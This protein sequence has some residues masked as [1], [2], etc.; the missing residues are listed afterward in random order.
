M[1]AYSIDLRQRI[2][3]AVETGEDSQAEVAEQYDVSLSSVERLLR[4]WRTTHS[5]AALAG[6]PGPKRTLEPYGSWLRAEVQRQPDVSLAELCERLAKTQRVTAHP[7]MMWRELRVLNLPLKK[8][9]FTTASA[10]RHA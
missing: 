1:K 6:T 5:V 8:S 10:T 7:S 3:A 2:V 9:R 4:R